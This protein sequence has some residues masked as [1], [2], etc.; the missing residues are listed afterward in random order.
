MGQVPPT[1]YSHPAVCAH[2]EHRFFFPID[3]DTHILPPESRLSHYKRGSL[4][5][6]SASPIFSNGRGEEVG[7]PGRHAA[8]G[9][10]QTRSVSTGRHTGST[11]L[12]QH[13][14]ESA[15]LQQIMGCFIISTLSP[16][17]I[18]PLQIWP[19]HLVVNHLTGRAF[20]KS[21]R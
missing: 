19:T 9:C 3:P 20:I 6:W 17:V 1:P 21:P 4:F 14:I 7:Q 18:A 8:Q 11:Q 13:K 10:I 16:C 15:N 5:Y 2:T 12:M